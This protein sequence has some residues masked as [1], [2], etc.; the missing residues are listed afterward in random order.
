MAGRNRILRLA[1]VA[2][3]A[4][5]MLSPHGPARAEI[6]VDLEL[7]LAIDA[8]DS[9]DS[10]EF[11][12]Q[13]GGL[14]VAFHDAEVHEAID[15]GMLGSIAVAVVEWSSQNEQAVRIPW[16][17]IDGPAAAIAVAEEIASLRRSFVGGVTAISSLID[18]A[19]DLF[20][21]N[22]FVS[23]RRVIDISSDGVQNQGRRL[24]LARDDAMARD[25]TINALVIINEVP[26]LDEYFRDRVIGGFGSFVMIALDYVDYRDAIRRKLIREIGQ[27]PVSSLPE[28]D[29]QLASLP[30]APARGGASAWGNH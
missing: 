20:D 22:G 1:G 14:A 3:L 10:K 16:T 13:I 19:A 25:I 5:G 6:P 8:S 2:A 15:S 9:V 17:R 21:G 29:R 18:Y 24:D 27:S 12:L 7:V 11:A 23:A 28:G 4:L 26:N 30:D